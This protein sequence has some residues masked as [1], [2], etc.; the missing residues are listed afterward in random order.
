MYI[1]NENKDTMTKTINN[2]NTMVSNSNSMNAFELAELNGRAKAMK[3]M[4][5]II[6]ADEDYTIVETSNSCRWDFEVVSKTTKE[7][8]AIVEV[9]DRKMKSDD[10]RVTRE[11]VHLDDDKYTYLQQVCE[12]R[13]I[14]GYFLATFNDDKGYIWN[15]LSSPTTTHTRYSNRTTAE[16]TDKVWKLF[17]LFQVGDADLELEIEEEN[18]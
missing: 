4:E 10:K 13:H 17:R 8:L 14:D 15:L 5:S 6:F 3:M 9:K 18:A 12:K 11:G 7:V 2:T 16:L 1:D